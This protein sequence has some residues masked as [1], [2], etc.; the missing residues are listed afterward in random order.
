MLGTAVCYTD[1]QNVGVS[2]ESQ[3]KEQLSHIIP[4]MSNESGQGQHGSS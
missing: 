4:E 1:E 3:D 2:R